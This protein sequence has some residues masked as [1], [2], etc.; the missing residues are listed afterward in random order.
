[1]TAYGRRSVGIELDLALD[2]GLR[3]LDV[4]P[5]MLGQVVANLLVNAAQVLVQGEDGKC[6]V[7][8]T[9]GRDAF[10]AAG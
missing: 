5:D 9:Y 7:E 1:M 3:P 2:P 8:W 6:R 4:D 10:P